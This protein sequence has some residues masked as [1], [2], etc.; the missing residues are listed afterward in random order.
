MFAAE[1]EAERMQGWPYGYQEKRE[2]QRDKE[3][4]CEWG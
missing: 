3:T 1:Q 4:A 2:R